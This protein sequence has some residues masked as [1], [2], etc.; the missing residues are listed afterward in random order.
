MG[1]RRQQGLVV[2]LGNPA[3]ITSVSDLRKP[4][5]RLATRQE[6]S[7]SAVLLSKLV[8]DAGLNLDDLKVAGQPVSSETDIAVAVREG[9]PTRPR[10][11]GGRP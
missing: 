5:I 2:A 10:N 11:R 4:G 1:A 7:G 9:K 8:I 6:G 3:R